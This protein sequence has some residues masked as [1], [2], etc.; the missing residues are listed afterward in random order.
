MAIPQVDLPTTH[1]VVRTTLN[2]VITLANGTVWLRKT[3]PYNINERYLRLD[4]FPDNEGNEYRL[5]NEALGDYQ[6]DIHNQSDNAARSI[7]VKDFSG[8]QIGTIKPS[9]AI[10][11]FQ[12]ASAP[13]GDTAELRGNAVPVLAIADFGDFNSLNH[14]KLP[15]GTSRMTGTGSQYSGYPVEYTLDPTTPYECEI[16]TVNEPGQFNQTITFTS[17]FSVTD[18]TPIGRPAFRGG[19]NLGAAITSGWQPYG[20]LSDTLETNRPLI[21]TNADGT[22]I[23]EIFQDDTYGLVLR[24]EDVDTSK[25][26]VTL[27]GS[28]VV[29]GSE[30]TFV[31]FNGAQEGNFVQLGAPLDLDG[32]IVFP[33]EATP[34]NVEVHSEETTSSADVVLTTSY[35]SI[36]SYDTTKSYLPDSSSASIQFRVENTSNTARELTY[37]ITV[38][39]APPTPG[40]EFKATV[41]AKSGGNNGVLLISTNDS[42][43]ST[44][45]I[46]DTVT[47]EMVSNGS[48]V[49]VTG[50]VLATKLK[51]TQN[52]SIQSEINELQNATPVPSGCDF[53]V[54]PNLLLTTTPTVLTGWT[55]DDPL[56]NQGVSESG[57]EFTVVNAAVYKVDLERVYQ[58]NDNNPALL[59][60][61]TIT[62]EAKPDGGSYAPIFSRTAPISS[63]TANDEPAILSFTT[64]TNLPITANS[65]FRIL[66][67]AEDGGGNPQ[68][69]YF[70]RAKVVANA[71]RNL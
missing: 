61:V 60:N 45:N 64:P 12:N 48:G 14:D 36:I 26:P 4:V 52:S 22:R 17:G 31:K 43:T 44:I 50:T 66:V 67:S 11:Y 21:V 56:Y 27:V 19:G 7:I 57:G 2:D 40:D 37:Y 18:T 23:G 1:G 24:A 5:P 71:V 33:L 10:S 8:A 32:T 54:V 41:P 49:T 38:N 63:A 69:C 53:K 39:G 29:V 34:L 16:V 28:T 35:Q 70:V 65:K 25:L 20:K 13:T 55:S 42:S 59:V 9:G 58:N 15:T 3:G 6:I 62:V 47:C 68:E 46:G 51:I 30:N